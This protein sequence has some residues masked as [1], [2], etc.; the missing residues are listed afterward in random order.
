MNGPKPV[1][2]VV[3]ALLSMPLAGN[4]LAAETHSV[5][6]GSTWV[7]DKTTTLSSL[8]IGK[9]AVVKAP[10]GYSLTLTVNGVQRDLLP[11]TYRGNVVLA[12]TENN[13]VPFA[14]GSM[15]QDYDFRQALYVD[16]SGIVAGKSVRS[17][18][19]GGTLTASAAKNVRIS[20][21]GTNFNG[22][23]VT[24]G[25][26]YSVDDARIDFNGNGENDFAGYGAAVMAAGKGTTLVL[27]HADISSRGVVR[28]TII[29]A[30]GANVVVKNSRIRGLDGILPA[31]YRPSG[32]PH[33]WSVPWM[34]GLVGTMRATS[35][36]GE[37]TTAAYIHSDIG[38]QGWGALSTDGVHDAQLVAVNSKVVITGVSGYGAYN[39][40][41]GTTD[42]FYGTTFN[43]AD[44]GVIATGGTMNFGASTPERVAEL[45]TRLHWGLTASELGA[46]KQRQTVV[47]S[48]RFGV[49]FW[50]SKGIANV[51]DSTVF[52]TRKAVF[53]VRGSV[54]EINVDGAQ[55]ARLNSANGMILQLM[56]RDKA[57]SRR[58]AT[59]GTIYYDTYYTE[60]YDSYADIVRD[61]AHDA[62]AA[63]DADVVGNFRN[64]QLRGN[65]YNGVTGIPGNTD[66][67]SRNLVLNFTHAGV[68]GAISATFAQ[69][70]KKSFT[71]TDRLLVSEVSNT[72][73][74]AINNGVIVSLDA[75]SRW[76][77]TGT[78]YLT[79]LVV[80]DGAAI[81]APAGKSVT[82]SV[83]GQSRPIA[84]GTYSGA[85]VLEV[86]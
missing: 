71:Y 76:T 49:M 2:A 40:G 20:S 23:Y 12:V 37:N 22:I 33:M 63:S 32:P 83:D 86:Q 77:V 43:V 65:F 34:L 9:D 57:N 6:A 1:A 46:L 59:T 44:Y 41:N 68:T 24:G 28:T 72:P 27:D 53:V 18:V 48:G 50:N 14:M 45:N 25:A 55:G 42:S 17:A 30:D 56:D 3:A 52:N 11:A 13:V 79:R 61:P 75:A 36:L 15:K 31:D 5:A 54:A 7:V 73:H 58:D 81:T 82:L 51:A 66:Y 16:S 39:D 38:A 84:A 35:I 67:P 29:G 64:I 26:H 70:A 8:A 21:Q 80:A 60:P 4:A 19:R 10:D 69:H 62:T 85:I 78:S 74:A 47:N